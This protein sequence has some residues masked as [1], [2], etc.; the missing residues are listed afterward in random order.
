MHLVDRNRL[1]ALVGLAPVLQMGLVFPLL[2]QLGGGD[3]G[4][5]RSELAAA[6]EGIGLQR[7]QYAILA[8]DLEL[9]GDADRYVRGKDFPDAAVG[10]E[11]HDVAAAVPIVEITDDGD[12]LRVWR[13]DGEMDA[14]GAVMLDEVGAHLVEQA[15][16]RALAGEIIIHR[17]EHRTEAVGIGD[18]PFGIAAPGAVTHRLELGEGNRAGEDAVGMELF[19]FA[20]DAAVERHGGHLLRARDEAPGD[21]SVAGLVHT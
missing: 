8:A 2:L 13:P 19:Q 21:E 17:S 15:Q 11:A 7:Q 20:N 1:A 16:V 5:L 4:G 14:L 9:V 10:T 6:G 3:R 18:G 12:A